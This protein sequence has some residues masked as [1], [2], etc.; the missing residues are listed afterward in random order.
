MSL[1][2]SYSRTHALTYSHTHLRTYSRTC[3]QRRRALLRCHA[4]LPRLQ[5]LRT[6]RAPLRGV[7]RRR[8]QL[9]RRDF[10]PLRPGVD[11]ARRLRHIMQAR[12][13]T[14][15]RRAYAR[16]C[17]LAP[18]VPTRLSARWLTCAHC[19]GLASFSSFEYPLA[20]YRVTHCDLTAI[21][22]RLDPKEFGDGA[23]KL[24]A[25]CMYEYMY[26]YT[27]VYV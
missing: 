26:I 2:R 7:G 19:C 4:D 17:L 18:A 1:L 24:C 16:G 13:P 5:R 3:S 25:A 23:E 15:S 10:R 21:S 22:R 12:A 14:C 11:A 6:G 20:Y 9:H 27:Y 8:A